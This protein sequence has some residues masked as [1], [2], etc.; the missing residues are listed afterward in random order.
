MKDLLGVQYLVND[1]RLVTIFRSWVS[2]W[3]ENTVVD[4]NQV[5]FFRNI[6]KKN[7]ACL[8]LVL[9][10]LFGVHVPFIVLLLFV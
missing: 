6:C 1:G 4:S 10:C 9:L 3:W 5:V 2:T 8:L 7:H